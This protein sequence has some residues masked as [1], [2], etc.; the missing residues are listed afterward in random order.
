MLL[1]YIIALTEHCKQQLHTCD[2]LFSLPDFSI[3][4][5]CYIKML[6]EMSVVLPLAII[7]FQFVNV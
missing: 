7:V 5:I 1:N 4:H 2:C 3:I 6:I